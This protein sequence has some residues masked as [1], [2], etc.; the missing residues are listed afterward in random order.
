MLRLSGRTR[1]AGTTRNQSNPSPGSTDVLFRS[2]KA[3]V[4]TPEGTFC[5]SWRTPTSCPPDPSPSHLAVTC[6]Q[7]LPRPHMRTPFTPTGR[8]GATPSRS[9]CCAPETRPPSKPL[10]NTLAILA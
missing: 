9:S 1:D 5:P 6:H 8:T 10:K 4:H 2:T 7:P 3:V